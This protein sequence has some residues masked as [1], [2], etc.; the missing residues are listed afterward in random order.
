MDNESANR[1]QPYLQKLSKLAPTIM[2]YA[3]RAEREAQ[4]PREVA[5]AFHEAGLFRIF[6]PKS[7]GGGELTIP[8]SLRLCEEAARIDGSTGWNLVICSGG[9]VLG[10][11]LRRD[12]FDTIFRDPRAVCAGSLNPMTSRTMKVDGGWRF[13]GCATYASGSGHASYLMVAALVTRDGSP[14]IVNGAPNIRAGLFPI[15]SAKVLNTWSTTG[16]RGTGS[17][18]CTFEDVFIPDEFSF[19]WMNAKSA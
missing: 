10:H 14:E 7:M 8:E 19:D 9:P 11:M 18:D 2:Q 15:K 13:S 5:D 6:L 1:L 16:M 17:N 12:A 3:D 4:M